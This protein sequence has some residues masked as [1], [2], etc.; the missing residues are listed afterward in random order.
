MTSPSSSKLSS[1]DPSPRDVS[2]VGS[3]AVTVL[4]KVALVGIIIIVL[5]LLAASRLYFPMDGD[6]ALFLTAARIIDDG[7]V[8]YVDF[9]DVKQPG[10]FYFFWLAGKL[11]GFT[12][13]GLQLFQLVYWAIVGT[14]VCILV[15]P[16]FVHSWVAVL[17][18]F[19][20]LATYY[21][22]AGTNHHAQVEII[23]SGPLF[24][25][26]MCLAA[27]A[28]CADNGRNWRLI[29]AGSFGACVILLKIALA[30]ILIGFF[31]AY[32]VLGL[33]SDRTMT[34]IALD[35]AIVLAGGTLVLAV[36]VV[37]LF[38]D[39][40]LNG[41]I[42]TAFLTGPEW[43]RAAPQAPLPRLIK[44]GVSFVHSFGAW[45]GLAVIGLAGMRSPIR[46]PL[47]AYCCAW[48]LGAVI[49]VLIQRFSWWPYHWQLFY[50]PTAVMAALGADC[51]LSWLGS[52]W[53][54]G[55]RAKVLIVLI[56]LIPFVVA[57]SQVLTE[58]KTLLD[59]HHTE[60]SQSD[61]TGF[62]AAVSSRYARAAAIVAALPEDVQYQSVYVM[63]D[64]LIYVILDARQAIPIHGWSLEFFSPPDWAKLVAQLE[65]NDAQAIFLTSGYQNLVD[66]K[67][68]EIRDFLA[69]RYLRGPELDT[70]EWYFPKQVQQNE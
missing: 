1:V 18:P 54:F 27:A 56:A 69:S 6:G 15:R 39:G 13:L 55:E 62:R 9:W 35:G 14:A 58:R 46:Q 43:A 31:A 17:V 25:S 65:S 12:F 51:C 61:Y 60:I 3:D 11:F 34:K 5:G 29:L 21:A 42:E 67:A 10:I 22:H 64:P 40:G 32:L 20:F 63:G 19:A 4:L 16:Y 59:K 47:A 48:I 66:E 33:R 2:D 53:K 30:P 36:V 57:Y 28:K 70:G 41:A 26:A 8:L 52:R 49:C 23:A 50:L 45:I 68:P 38:L 37:A 44:G 7:G 24:L